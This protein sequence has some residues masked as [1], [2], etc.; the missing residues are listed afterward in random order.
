VGGW[1]F[2]RPA[3]AS[4]DMSVVETRARALA[5]AYRSGSA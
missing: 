2:P 4:G 5:E 3:F 1:L